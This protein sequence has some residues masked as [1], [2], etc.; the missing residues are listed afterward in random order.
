VRV[1]RDSD[2]KVMVRRGFSSEGEG[3]R[4]FRSEDEGEEE[5]H[6]RR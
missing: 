4:R 2:Q 3:K 5:I 6:F 1:K